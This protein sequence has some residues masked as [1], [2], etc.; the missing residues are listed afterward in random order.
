MK[1]FLQLRELSLSSSSSA[2]SFLIL[3]LWQKVIALSTHSG[4]D[5]SL[6]RAKNGPIKN[7][8]I[9]HSLILIHG[10]NISIYK[11]GKRE[12]NL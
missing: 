6:L 12:I 10:V 5:S 7:E 2:F 9:K 8:S 1:R 4:A 3:C 11:E